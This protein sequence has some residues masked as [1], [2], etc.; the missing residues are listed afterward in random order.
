VVVGATPALLKQR[1]GCD[2]TKECQECARSCSKGLEIQ[3]ECAAFCYPCSNECIPNMFYRVMEDSNTYALELY[4]SS[5]CS[6]LSVLQR[7]PLQLDT[8]KSFASSCD[9]FFIEVR[10]D[11]F[12]WSWML[13]LLGVCTGVTSLMILTL[14]IVRVFI[15][16]VYNEN[17]S[18]IVL[19]QSFRHKLFSWLTG[20]GWIF[21]LAFIG[22][23]VSTMQQIAFYISLLNEGGLYVYMHDQPGFFDTPFPSTTRLA[24]LLDVIGAVFISFV[25]LQY[26]FSKCT[27]ANI[28]F[29]A[30][31]VGLVLIGDAMICVVYVINL[32]A[33]QT[34]NATNIVIF[35]I[36]LLDVLIDYCFAL[37]LI[38]FAWKY[39]RVIIFRLTFQQKMKLAVIMVGGALLAI[40]LYSY[41]PI[42]FPNLVA[43]AIIA[44]AHADWVFQ[45]DY[46]VKFWFSV[47]FFCEFVNIMS[48]S[49]WINIASSAPVLIQT[50]GTVTVSIF[51]YL[52]VFMYLRYYYHNLNPSEA[53]LQVIQ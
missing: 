42:V 29:I 34:V 46:K 49:L 16:R 27:W 21:I 8:C 51:Y 12:G 1:C 36:T 40:P 18:D 10:A 28:I 3:D 45:V 37:I 33:N 11:L 30:V 5:S 25:F 26:Q 22:A 2:I 4:N 38:I 31:N 9:T 50:V 20:H 15:K 14:V 19:Y 53:E 17:T 47:F 44:I 23:F 52:F 24:P 7:L 13:I 48:M 43:Y 32:W 6:R 35:S 39:P 41:F